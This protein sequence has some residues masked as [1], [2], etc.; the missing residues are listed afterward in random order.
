[1]L[2]STNAFTDTQALKRLLSFVAISLLSCGFVSAGTLTLQD[3]KEA[4]VNSKKEHKLPFMV[5]DF[6]QVSDLQCGT[7]TYLGKPTYEYYIKIINATL[8]LDFEKSVK[9]NIFNETCVKNFDPLS[10]YANRKYIYFDSN[11]VKITEVFISSD[12]C[13]GTPAGRLATKANKLDSKNNPEITQAQYLEQLNNYRDTDS[14]RLA[15]EAEKRQKAKQEEDNL[16]LANEAKRQKEIEMLEAKQQKEVEVALVKKDDITCKSYGAKKGSP[17]Y[18]QCRSTQVANRQEAADRQKTIDALEK[19]INILQSQI[20]SQSEAQSAERDKEQRMS[21]EQAAS[22]QEF[23]NKQIELQKAQLR[24]LQQQ[25]AQ[26]R[27][28]TGS[29]LD[30]FMEGVKKYTEAEQAKRD[31]E[32]ERRRTAY[33]SPTQVNQPRRTRTDCKWNP[34][35][36]EYQC[37]TY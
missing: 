11:N 2:Y 31:K 35:Y 20:K 29:T 8:E 22:D 36:Q 18:V 5:G 17:A 23:K 37:T 10:E 6:T 16:R 15:D 4:V 33:S 13:M 19:R 32:N 12:E 26:A 28:A 30:Q 1:M 9:E 21:A 25:Q 34:N 7:A 24:V 14:K 3:C 27:E